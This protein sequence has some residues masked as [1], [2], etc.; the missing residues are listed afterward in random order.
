M[1]TTNKSESVIIKHTNESSYPIPYGQHYCPICYGQ[2][3]TGF[4]CINCGRQFCPPRNTK[5]S[6]PSRWEEK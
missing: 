2:I 3:D 5:P 4:R 6:I 1:S